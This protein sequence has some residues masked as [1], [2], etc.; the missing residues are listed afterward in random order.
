LLHAS[1]NKANTNDTVERI[2]SWFIDL[3]VAHVCVKLAYYFHG[4]LLREFRL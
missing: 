4:K 1:A 3:H 2:S